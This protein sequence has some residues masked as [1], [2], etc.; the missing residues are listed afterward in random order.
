M[1]S[2]A[3]VSSVKSYATVLAALLTLTVITVTAASVDFGSL[4]IVIALG[5][6]TIKASLVALFFMHLRGGRPMNG[7]IFVSG[8]LFLGVFLMF[9]L[10]DAE[11]RDVPR[12]T[13]LV[14]LPTA[15]V[16]RNSS[17]K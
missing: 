1:D 13:H 15:P 14:S 6:A 9:C 16:S 17:S 4:N 7:I 12:P 3:H 8:V 5:I 11:S 2:S 10:I